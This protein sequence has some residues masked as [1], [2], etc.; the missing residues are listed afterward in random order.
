MTRVYQ[1]LTKPLALLLAAASLSACGVVGEGGYIRDR[2][3]DYLKAK[4]YPRLNIPEELDGKSTEGVMVVPTIRGSVQPPKEFILPRPERVVVRAE[5][6]EFRV[7]KS[8]QLRWLVT[9]K[10]KQEVWPLLVEFWKDNKVPLETTDKAAGII[11]TDWIRPKSYSEQDVIGQFILGVIG[12]ENDELATDKFKLTIVDSEVPGETRYFLQHVREAHEAVEEGKQVPWEKLAK[13]TDSLSAGMLNELLL[14][15]T[16]A[17]KTSVGLVDQNLPV[18]DRTF[19]EQDGNGNPILLIKT[20]FGLA[21]TSVADALKAANVRV[22]DKNRTAGLFYIALDAEQQPVPEK[23]EEGFFSG[24]LGG[25]E[26]EV[27]TEGQETYQIRLTPFNDEVQVSVERNIN[28][29]A[30]TS[31]SQQ[32]LQ[33]I[34]EHLG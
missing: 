19:I 23:Q 17:A 9:N 29:I 28:T 11:E 12:D 25:D 31:V 2:S 7:E 22:T 27:V 15:L 26:K 5:T 24:I 32:L 33:L 6:N 4:S 18:T 30:P 1:G 8:G 13:R 3:N 16:R 34:K 10:P 20:G 14:Y 21:W